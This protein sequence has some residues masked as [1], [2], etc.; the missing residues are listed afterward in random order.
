MAMYYIEIYS[1]PVFDKLYFQFYRK[2]KEYCDDRC[3][4]SWQCISLL[5]FGK[6][7][8]ALRGPSELDSLF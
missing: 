3:L 4:M 6:G 1:S 5:K 2:R 8:R 7:K